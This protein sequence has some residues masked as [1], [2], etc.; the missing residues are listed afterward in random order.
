MKVSGFTIIKN[1]RLYDFPIREAI[2]S[3]LPICDEVVVAVGDCEDDTREMIA[4]ISPQKIRIID[5]VWNKQL[6]SG[7][8]VL[9]DETNKAFRAIDAD[10][11]WCFYI[12][13]DEVVHEKYLDNIYQC[14]LGAKDDSRVDG[15]LFKYLHFYGSYDY[16]GASS[17]WYRDEIRIIKNDKRIYSYKDAQGFRKGNN[18]K[19]NVKAVD[20]SIFHYGWVREPK[21][22]NAKL[23]NTGSYWGGK[24]FDPSKHEANYEGEFDYGQID[25]LK[26]FKGTHPAAMKPRIQRMNWRFEHD[27]TFRKYKLKDIFKNLLE[28]LTGKRFFD[29]KN[30]KLIK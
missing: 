28:K 3:I 6:N 11:D 27:L 21:K 13:G 29:Y 1:A 15:L 12:Q 14:M 9:A 26:K 24:D 2:L 10:A 8:E 17:N 25:A 22:M 20:A 19:L 30:Y 16:V 7:G 5:T 23:L 4:A 18:E